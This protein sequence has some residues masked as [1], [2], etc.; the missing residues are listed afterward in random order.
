MQSDVDLFFRGAGDGGGKGGV[1]LAVA[2]AQHGPFADG[3]LQEVGVWEIIEGGA[4]PD[5]GIEGVVGDDLAVFN[6]MLTFHGLRKY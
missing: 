6:R 3:E 2:Q 1:A 5:A 4:P